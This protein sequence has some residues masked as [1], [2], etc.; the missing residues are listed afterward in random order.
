MQSKTDS[1]SDIVYGDLDTGVSIDKSVL[2]DSSN[3]TIPF[4]PPNTCGNQMACTRC[5]GSGIEPSEKSTHA[6]DRARVFAGS[7][8]GES[9]RTNFFNSRAPRRN[10]GYSNR[11]DTRIHNDHRSRDQNHRQD[12][13]TNRNNGRNGRNDRNNG[14]RRD[15]RSYARGR[16]HYHSQRRRS[17]SPRHQGNRNDD[18]GR[19]NDRGRNYLRNRGSRYE[20]R[21]SCYEDR[22]RCYEDRGR[23]EHERASDRGRR[24]RRERYEYGSTSSSESDDDREDGED[25]GEGDKERDGW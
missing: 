17:L 13:Y 15:Y 22:G 7:F 16:Y 9:D 24:R 1:I 10:R 18:R 2:I 5:K 14:D 8:A 25:H 19:N 3:C 23:N 21:G 20:D 11:S 12:R 4:P 6:A